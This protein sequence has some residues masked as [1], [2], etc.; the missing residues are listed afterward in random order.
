MISM[1]KNNV[2]YCILFIHLII[3]SKVIIMN[4][5][6]INN[7]MKDFVEMV[8][9]RIGSDVKQCRLYGSCARGDYDE[10][11]D[12]DVILL[13]G[14]NRK[15]AEK[16]TDI[17]IDIVTELAMKYY[18]V[19]NALCVPYSEYEQKKSWYDFFANI[20]REGRVIY[21]K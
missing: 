17:L 4:D 19:I 5:L 14:C 10:F 15:E 21:G 18:V 16:Y 7:A 11:S 6:V 12:I 9:V 2:L 13:T 8:Q 1:L 3:E 20:E